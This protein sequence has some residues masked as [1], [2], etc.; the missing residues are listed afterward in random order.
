MPLSKDRW[1]EV[2][3]SPYPHEREALAFVRELLPD[4]EPYRAWSNLEFQAED[5]SINEVDLLVLS[6]KGAFV[7]EIKSW[8]GLIR[9]DW[10]GWT[11][12]HEGRTHSRDN[13]LPLLDRKCKRLKAVLSRHFSKTKVGLPF[14]EPLLF[15]SAGALSADGTKLDGL[16]VELDPSTS[17]NVFTRADLR[18]GLIEIAPEEYAR[19]R[20]VDKP[21][22]KA[23]AQ[24]MDKA[25]IRQKVRRVSDYKLDRLLLEGC[26][27]QDWE[28]SHVS[29]AD[30]KKRVRVYGVAAAATEELRATIRRAAERE[31]R[32]LRGIEHPGILRAEQF[33]EAEVGPALVFSHDPRAVRLDHYVREHYDRLT[34][35]KRIRLLREVA[36]A[37]KYAHGKGLVHRAL[38]P[39]SIFLHRPDDF[40]PRVVVFNWQTGARQPGTTTGQE[41]FPRVT[42]TEHVD[43]LVEDAAACYM[44]PEL[45]SGHSAEGEELDVFSLGALAWFLFTGKPPAESGGELLKKVHQTQGLKIDA[46]MD[47]APPEL[48]ELIK[49]ATH[50]D[51]RTRMGT[52]TDFLEWLDQVEEAWSRPD[53]AA[54]KDPASAGIGE[55]LLGG[56]KVLRRL[57]KG[58]SAVAFVVA[59]ENRGGEFVLKVAIDSEQ[60]DRLRGEGEVLQKL[61]HS[62]L[63]VCKEVVEIGDRVALLL[64]RAGRETLRDR[65]TKDGPLQI[66]LLERFGADLL[67]AVKYLESE[68]INHRDIK[69][70][71]LGIAE[72]G[73][74]S[75]LHLVLFDFSLS[76][77]SAEAI[78]AGTRLY[79]DPFLEHRRTR[80]Y[81]LHAERFAAAMTLHEMA[82][83]VLPRWGDGESSPAALTCEVSL[84]EERFPADQR[85][86]LA[87]FFRRALA[88]DPKAR[89]GNGEE[90]LHAWREVFRGAASV[91]PATTTPDPAEQEAREEAQ[92]AALRKSLEEATL[93]TPTA[94]LALGGRAATALA[95][96]GAMTVQDFLELP[97]GELYHLRGVGRKTRDELL[98]AYQALKARFPTAIPKAPGS[99][100]AGSL[101]EQV[102][103]AL[104]PKG[105]GLPKGSSAKAEAADAGMRLLLGV[106]V[107]RSASQ[108]WWPS[109]AEVAI[110]RAVT[111]ASVNLALGRSRKAWAKLP[112][113]TELRDQ[114]V[115]RIVAAGGVMTPAELADALLAARGTLIV[116]RTLAARHAVAIARAAIET[117]THAA[118]PRLV[119]RRNDGRVFVARDGD[120]YDG[121]RLIDAALALGRL[122]DQTASDDP[123]PGPTDVKQRIQDTPWPDEA[124][125]PSPLRLARLAASASKHA[126]L[127]GQLEF[128]PR[129][130]SAERAIRLAHGALLGPTEL[131][132]GDIDE[133]LRARYPEC[134]ELPELS[135]LVKI[136]EDAGFPHRYDKSAARGRGAFRVPESTSVSTEPTG[137]SRWSTALDKPAEVTEEVAE[138]RA[139][140]K[141]LL[142]AKKDG[143][144]LVLSVSPSDA[145]LAERALKDPRFALDPVSFEAVFLDA[146]RNQAAENDVD[147][148]LVLAADREAASSEDARNLRDLV[149]MTLP[150]VEA[151]IGRSERTRLLTCLG[152]LARYDQL[153]LLERLRDRVSARPTAD[154]PGLFGL[155]VLVPCDDQASAPMLDDRAV[156]VITRAQWARIPHSW[157]QNQHRGDKHAPRAKESQKATR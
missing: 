66:D 58:S 53:T 148:D 44:A 138:A 137:T 31:Y 36:D 119:I 156:P 98:G 42:A 62:T 111:P 47:G 70:D 109:Q 26:G 117:E 133:R 61:H 97:A 130:L 7:V 46:V 143:A 84:D 113:V 118:D 126:C 122:A 112:V 128:Y 116:D 149:S 124:R 79:L 8:P 23:T 38:S 141:R 125:R 16:K 103:V 108:P 134:E 1:I 50:P 95:R 75:E 65:L 14:F 106:Q 15:L 146:L 6:P 99:G 71:N 10:G 94:A 91:P 17:R 69:P 76:R 123:L 77:A 110:E 157:V 78:T 104:L 152:P 9:G 131:T 4:H 37:I 55:V 89:F 64:D 2:T 155:W 154:D 101:V 35:D 45:F 129:G 85:A 29:I 147:W 145:A 139:F 153:A 136:L 28:A 68:G 150:D 21:I 107:P 39:Q 19:L 40:D 56:F 142:R 90:M 49:F 74:N 54:V 67:D 33:T 83:G 24:A 25:G 88:R 11:W 151:R 52:V 140:D 60:N 86:A 12:T 30:D 13:P 96:L 73:R 121:A 93:E 41:G 59:D 81:D 114:V 115:E 120:G 20:R 135:E 105:T 100:Q 48:S 82:T 127:S 87:P 32:I 102:L 51:R 63:V 43:Q 22:A 72:R 132:V 80:R 3:P 34:E 5:G 144:F 27:Y 92:R 18:A 57:G